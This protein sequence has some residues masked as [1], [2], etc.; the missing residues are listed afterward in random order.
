MTF[1]GL[2]PR[3]VV[4]MSGGVD[5][6]V[7]AYILK[8]QGY[9]VIG[10]FMKN[11]EEQDED[12][13]CTAED[14]FRDVKRV[15]EKIGIPYYSVN[16]AKEYRNRVFAEFLNGLKKGWTPNP[17]ILCNREIKFGP[18][19]EKA[20]QMGADYVATGHYANIVHVNAGN[21]TPGVRHLLCRAD[22]DTK[23]QSY[24]LC[25]L[26]QEQLARVMFPLAHLKKTAVREIAE[27]IGLINARK[28]DST[29]I[30]F[31][32]ERKIKQFLA[33]Y[34][35]N[36]KG[37][38][39]TLDGKVIGTHDGLM[40]YTI[41]QRKGMAIGGRDGKSDTARWFVIRKSLP[42]NILY[43]NNG[44]CPELYS[45]SLVMENFNEIKGFADRIKCTAKIRYRQP[46]AVVP[47]AVKLSSYRCDA[48][49]RYRQLDQQCVV[50]EIGDGKIRVV[51]DTPQRAVT[52]GQ[53]CVLYDGDGVLGGGIIT[54][55]DNG[56]IADG[57]EV[58]EYDK[59]EVTDGGIITGVGE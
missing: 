50:T 30:C 28:K 56:E 52:P 48:K 17:D 4:G 44:D 6:S 5:S 10:L 54:G 38:I 24:F 31:I 26:S 27:R 34:L 18:F 47:P 49:I 39:R 19:L 13:C 42:H 7:T 15:C 58:T 45:K 22:D 32:G 59:G 9:E 36:Q 20:K 35:G 14:D 55:Y 40:Y 41:G 57:G 51:F 29:G 53:W 21:A 2:P 37:E 25:G 43:V 11:W 8:W 16:F 46:E 1:D 3:V 33:T 12:G 23:D